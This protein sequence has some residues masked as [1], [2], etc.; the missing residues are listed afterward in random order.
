VGLILNIY[1]F[2]GSVLKSAEERSS[3]DINIKLFCVF[4]YGG[5]SLVDTN[6]VLIHN[7]TLRN[8]NY[9]SIHL[10]VICF[11][12]VHYKTV[13][14]YKTVHNKTVHRHYGILNNSTLQSQSTELNQAIDWLGVKPN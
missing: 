7:G 13:Q 1:L 11:K 2:V 9:T 5:R 3:E 8:G 4:C 6:M 12:T 10:L 14:W